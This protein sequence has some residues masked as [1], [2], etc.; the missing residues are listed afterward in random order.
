MLDQLGIERAHLIAHDY[1]ATVSWETVVNYPERFLSYCAISVGHSAEILKDILRGSLF[2][3]LWLILHG[4]PRLSRFL[5]LRR[6]AKRFHEKFASHPDKERILT[7]LEEGR[8]LRF[9]TVWEQANPAAEVVYRQFIRGERKR[10]IPLPVL[11][12][13]SNE[14]EWMT[15]GQMKRSSVY[16]T[17]SWRY[18]RLEGGH[19]VQLEQSDRINAILSRWLNSHA[20]D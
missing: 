2:R 10:T 9:W 14:D 13:Y 20:V 17:K 15:E 12:I 6:N 16:T 4:M 1:G 11:G 5:Y 3:Y 8:D 19:W 7:K 18:E